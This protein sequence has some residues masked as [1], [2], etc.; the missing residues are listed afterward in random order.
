MIVRMVRIETRRNA[1]LWVSPL[2]VGI[3]LLFEAG[4]GLAW[5]L[6][7]WPDMSVVIRDSIV[8]IGPAIAGIAA[9]MAGRERRRQIEDLLA[10]TPRPAFTR[11]AATWVG[12]VGWGFM[13]Y[14]AAAVIL[15]ALTLRHAVWGGPSLWPIF[16]GLLAIPAE[17]AVGYAL[18]VHLPGRFTA[19]LVAIAAFLAQTGV[20]Y[21]LAGGPA[22]MR[23]LAYLSPVVYLD[24]SVWY[25]VRPNVGL[26][27]ALVLFGLIA[28]G[29][30]ATALY[31]RASWGAWGSCCAGFVLCGTSAAMLLSNAPPT[32]SD[33]MASR[34]T[35]AF[36]GAKLTIW[37]KR[38]IPYTPACTASPM[39]VC[40]HPAYAPYLKD[41]AS[42]INR[43]IAPLRGL[44]GAPTRAVQRSDSAW[45]VIGNDLAFVPQE[46]PADESFY[47][48]IALALTAYNY[49]F[50]DFL[51]CPGD[52]TMQSCYEAQEAVGVW[53]VRQ[54]GL[55]LSLEE[56][57]VPWGKFTSDWRITS[58]AAQR[59]ARLSPTSQRAWL[60]AHY[61]TLR[62][63]GVPLKDVP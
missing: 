25:G 18:G 45:G 3:A 47:G 37:N 60:R 38:P 36:G 21:A 34:Y 4:Q 39:P 35:P 46:T 49:N 20:G 41:D 2:M 55:S 17:A 31:R 23:V 43:L 22:N 24:T 5:R 58:P 63:G 6:L 57:G 19:P 7:L 16:I 28:I 8:F 26:P 42:I 1:A 27:Q 30:G 52:A 40:V 12:T 13:A 48:Q 9:W 29:L 33:L 14:V 61:L 50:K 62:H 15:V 56:Q 44:P 11:R 10:T 32:S 51:H 53:L 59:F 54:A